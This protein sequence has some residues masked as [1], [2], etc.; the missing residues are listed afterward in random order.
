MYRVTRLQNGLTL[1]TAEMPHM[2][3]IC[4]GIWVGV[5]GRHESPELN[6][7]S[8]FLEHMLFK[9]TAKRTAREISHA[10]EGIGGSSNAFTGEEDTCYHARARHD[11]LPELL[12]VLMDM[13]S[14]SRFDP[15]EIEK[16]RGVIKEEL[17]MVLDEPDQHVQELLNETIW[18]D[19]PLGRPLTGTRKSLDALG[20][21]ALL[22]H[23]RANYVAGNTIIVGAGNL[24]HSQLL[25]AVHPYARHL[26]P[27][28][29]PKFLPVTNA[30]SAPAVGLHTRETAQ[31][32][33]ALGFRTCSR[34]DERRFALRLLNVMLGENTSSR[35][36]QVI[37]EDHGLAYSIHSSTAL[38]DDTGLLAISAGLDN[39]HLPQSLRLIMRE[40]KKFT[41]KP[42]GAAE[43][44]RA[45]DY[46]I[47]QLDL[48]LEN[49][50]NQM[51]WIG[52]QLLGHGKI[53]SPAELKEKLARVTAG[54]I[55]AVARDFFRPDR[56]NLA[57]VSPIKSSEPIK[58]LLRF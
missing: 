17:A 14:N 55:R 45:R 46:R 8:H 50:E 33:I 31:T 23:H 36:F 2:A 32:Q 30:P 38:L 6:G 24:H 28:S 20:R 5:G 19:H 22:G 53:T 13:F 34:H 58:K 4:L 25:K 26:R 52:E 41:E 15:A 35:L 18:P 57:V 21:A 47:G 39:G 54:Q 42:P 10:F 51:T 48:S 11:H 16:E 56:M 49:T 1:A 37:R 12:D 9:G 29:R 43:L 7:A 44:R 3:S 27:G 40:L